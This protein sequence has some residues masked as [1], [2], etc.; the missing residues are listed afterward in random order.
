[1]QSRQNLGIRP[2]LG[3]METMLEKLEYP[4]KDL[5]AIHIAGTNGK[6]STLTYIKQVLMDQG[7]TV[8]SFVSP[9]MGDIQEHILIGHDPISDLAFVD[10]LNKLLPIVEDMD[11]EENGPTEFELMVMIAILH[12]RNNT[13]IVLMEAG[14]GGREDS[15]NVLTPLLSIITNV[16]LDHMSFLGNTISE[17]A[18]QKAGIIKEGVPVVTG[19]TQREAKDV[20]HKMAQEK[21]APLYMLG[22]EFSIS[23]GTTY[24]SDRWTLDHI[25]FGMTGEHQWR[26][27]ALALKALELLFETLDG[28]EVRKSLARASLLGRFE[29]MYTNPTIIVDGAHNQEGIQACVQTA[30]HLFPDQNV[31]LLFA[32]FKDKPIVEMMEGAKGYVDDITL[33]IFDHHRAATVEELREKFELTYELVEDWKEFI[34]KFI[35][36]K[37]HDVLLITGSL[38]FI[39]KIRQYLSLF[40]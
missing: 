14:M 22:E 19:V 8:G 35:E 26:N 16:G 5:K 34:R 7:Y 6:G 12:F 37:P 13:D 31:H 36:E 32:A 18:M 33:T 23:N 28:D 9:S 21:Q 39:S 29:K 1:M 4:E 17:I 20:V 24:K 27:G 10:S 11:R 3:R 2:G 25:E 40:D 30:E 38:N 15:T